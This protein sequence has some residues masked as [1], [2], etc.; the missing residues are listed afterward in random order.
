MLPDQ[1][2][3]AMKKA[4][5]IEAERFDGSGQLI[6]KINFKIIEDHF[7]SYLERMVRS[8]LTQEDLEFYDGGYMA[9]IIEED[10]SLL[11][12]PTRKLMQLR[13]LLDEML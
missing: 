3:K 13:G 6:A 8:V 4:G 5:A 9:Y 7:P 1:I 11:W 10:G 12:K 2:L